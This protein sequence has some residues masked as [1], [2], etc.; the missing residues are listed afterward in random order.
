MPWKMIMIYYD[1]VYD[2]YDDYDYVDYVDCDY[3]NEHILNL[4]D[5]TCCMGASW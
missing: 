1:C 4:H 3:G 2:D 5:S